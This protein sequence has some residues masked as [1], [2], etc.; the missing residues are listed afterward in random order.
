MARTAAFPTSYDADRE[1]QDQTPL[2]RV[3]H[4]SALGF[5]ATPV[6]NLTA[7]APASREPRPVATLTVRRL[8]A[9]SLCAQSSSTRQCGDDRAFRGDRGVS[10][11]S[12]NGKAE[13]EGL[14]STREYGWLRHRKGPAGAR[15][16]NGMPHDRSRQHWVDLEAGALALDVDRTEP[17]APAPPASV[18]WEAKRSVAEEHDQQLS[19]ERCVARLTHGDI[20]GPWPRASRRSSQ[21]L[22]VLNQV[23]LL[24]RGQT[25]APHSV[26]MRNHVG[27]RCGTTVV[28]VRRMLP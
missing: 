21:R 8:S 22:Q 19:L 28:E 6:G 9:L 18:H 24:L 1:Q 11:S 20:R 13:L 12:S 4:D 15:R 14:D 10:N 3:G 25:E 2:N 7:E 26:V 27:E 17:P 16:R 23:S 5:E